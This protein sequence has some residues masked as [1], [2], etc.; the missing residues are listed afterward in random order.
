MTLHLN[1][2]AEKPPSA[3]TNTDPACCASRQAAGVEA[4]R[5]DKD[6]CAICDTG[7]RNARVCDGTGAL[8][9]TDKMESQQGNTPHSGSLPAGVT[10]DHLWACLSQRAEVLMW[11][12]LCL[13]VFV[14][15]CAS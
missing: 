5:P 7:V 12:T 9:G 4:M 8:S 2:S 15:A 1:S 3:Q 11:N 6:P 14:C 13:C 10:P